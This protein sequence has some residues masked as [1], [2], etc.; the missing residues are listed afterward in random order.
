MQLAGELRL[1]GARRVERLVLDAAKVAGQLDALLVE[2][3][4]PIAGEATDREAELEDHVLPRA[5][6]EGAALGGERPD[7]VAGE[8]DDGEGDGGVRL[9]LLDQRSA[10]SCLLVEQDRLEAEL[11]EEARDRLLDR[12]VPPVDDQHHSLRLFPSGGIGP[13]HERRVS[14]ARGYR[15][16]LSNLRRQ[17]VE[18]G[19]PGHEHG[20]VGRP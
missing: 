12:H 20:P 6:P 13:E 2:R 19:G 8:Q 7:V 15:L 5:R 14:Q 11:H 4:H 17:T 10:V 1:P 3:A 18:Q 9:E 16:E